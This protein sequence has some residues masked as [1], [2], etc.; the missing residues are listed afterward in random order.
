MSI[1][2]E[3]GQMLNGNPTGDYGTEEWQDALM[4]YLLEEI[5]RVHWNKYQEQWCRDEDPK[6]SGV[7]FRPY[8]WGDDET[9]AALPNMK[10]D[11]LTQE[12]RWYKHP[13][14]GQSCSLEL[15]KDEWV[16]W[17]NKALIIIRAND[18]KYE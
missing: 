16:D 11:G 10:F 12:I 4:D 1:E 3:L 17:F 15:T 14:R 6:L 5:D 7:E 13:G 18:N 2:P 9:E 8:Y